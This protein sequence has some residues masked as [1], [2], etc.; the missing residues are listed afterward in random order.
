MLLREIEYRK[1]IVSQ[2]SHC[3]TDYRAPWLVEHSMEELLMQ[4]ICGLALGYEDLND[5]DS[6][7]HDPLLAGKSVNRLGF[8]GRLDAAFQFLLWGTTGG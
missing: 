1:K 3:F 5:H 8:F 7:R 2:L 4:R 6:L